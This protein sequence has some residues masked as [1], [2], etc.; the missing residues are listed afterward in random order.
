MDLLEGYCTGAIEQVERCRRAALT[1]DTE[2]LG[3][4]AG[5]YTRSFL[6]ST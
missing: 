3:F 2:V 5:A 6:S 4:E 1:A